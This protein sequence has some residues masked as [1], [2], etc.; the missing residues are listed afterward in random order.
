MA[1]IVIAEEELLVL[2][3]PLPLEL[4]LKIL[5]DDEKDLHWVLTVVD[6]R[7]VLDDA[8]PTNNLLDPP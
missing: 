2:L 5:E 4:Q 3:L 8:T 1:H 7:P 6:W